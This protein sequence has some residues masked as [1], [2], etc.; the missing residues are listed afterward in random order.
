M[1]T[2]T[3]TINATGDD[4]YTIEREDVLLLGTLGV[5]M[6]E[7]D[8]DPVAVLLLNPYEFGHAVRVNPDAAVFMLDS[9]ATGLQQAREAILDGTFQV[10]E[11]PATH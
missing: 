9:W 11:L 3:P 10:P 6:A 2:L 5:H 8:S 4:D 7:E 1:T